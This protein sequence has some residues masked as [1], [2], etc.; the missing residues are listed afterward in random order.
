MV[1]AI[2]FDCFGVLYL[3]AHRALEEKFPDKAQELDEL[4]RQ[5]DYGFITQA[6]YVAAAMDI[7]GASQDDIYS[8]VISSY[9]FNEPLSQYIRTTLKP[10][11]KIAMLSNIGRGWIQNFFDEHQLHD[12]FDTVVLSGDE[13]VVKPHPQVFELVAERLE[14]EIEECLMVDDLPENIAGADAAGMKGIVYG[15]LRDLT[16]DF[17]KRLGLTS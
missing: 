17:N 5:S 1:K 14:L 3:G 16:Q 4:T 7:T 9:H 10:R 12:L 2:V 11:Y 8:L 15:N 13:G 6:E